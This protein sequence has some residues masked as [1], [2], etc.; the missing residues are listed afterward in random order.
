MHIS[1][2]P[3]RGNDL[4]NLTKRRRNTEKG[5]G[6]LNCM[7]VDFEKSYNRVPKEDNMALHEGI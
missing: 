1:Q 2:N 6:E 7:F 5:K 4:S 3:C